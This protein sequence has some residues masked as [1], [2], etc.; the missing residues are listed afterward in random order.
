DLLRRQRH[1]EHGPRR[2]RRAR[3]ARA[4][5]QRR[6]DA[7][8]ALDHLAAAGVAPKW[9]QTPG[10]AEEKKLAIAPAE[11]ATTITAQSSSTMSTIRPPVVSGF[12]SC[13]Y[14][15]R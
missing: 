7:A 10:S 4:A 9:S 1:R 8:T 5:V 2:R 11:P 6:A 3:V 13:V 15:V 14:A 12:G